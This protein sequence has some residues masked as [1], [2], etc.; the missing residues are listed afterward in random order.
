VDEFCGRTLHHFADFSRKE[1]MVG[2]LQGE[3]VIIRGPLD[4]T[5]V[6]GRYNIIFS[7]GSKL[8]R[9]DPLIR[10]TRV[11]GSTCILCIR[12]SWIETPKHFNENHE[13]MIRDISIVKR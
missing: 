2:I 5:E 4:L 10:A 12:V 6:Q 8:K 1:R 11:I 3:F 13:I 7:R 9:A